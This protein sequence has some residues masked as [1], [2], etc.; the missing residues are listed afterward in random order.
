MGGLTLIRL[1]PLGRSNGSVLLRLALVSRVFETG[2]GMS[3]TQLNRVMKEG[4]DR[5]PG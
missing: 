4:V 5:R 3:S 1:G 2:C